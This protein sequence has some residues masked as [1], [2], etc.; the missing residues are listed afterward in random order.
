MDKRRT[1]KSIDRV[2]QMDDRHKKRCADDRNVWSFSRFEFLTLRAL[3][4]VG[5]DASPFLDDRCRQTADA[6]GAIADKRC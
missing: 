3:D 4:A 5:V 2:R 6:A 1:H